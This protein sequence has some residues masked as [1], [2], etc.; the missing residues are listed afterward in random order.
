MTHTLHVNS[1]MAPAD[2]ETPVGIYLKLRDL[3]PESALLESSDYHTS[4]NS[5]SYIGVNPIGSFTVINE[6]TEAHYPDGSTSRN[7]II[8]PADVINRLKA[9]MESFT[10]NGDD[11]GDVCGL[12]GYT[13]YDCVRYFDK[14]DI[15]HRDPAYRDIPD[16]IGRA[17]V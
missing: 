1:R 7:P 8:T 5:V 9:Y 12:L 17:H 6:T 16:K 13:A 10:C 3:Y 4:Q 11:A 15:A 14:V 2:L